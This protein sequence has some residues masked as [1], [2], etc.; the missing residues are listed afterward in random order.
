VLP[1]GCSIADRIAECAASAGNH[2]GFV[3][4]VAGIAQELTYAELISGRQKGKLMSCSGKA[5]LP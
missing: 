2:G 1:G 5:G 3:S 4:C